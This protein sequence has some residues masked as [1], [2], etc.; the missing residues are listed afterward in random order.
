MN[1]ELKAL[2]LGI[3]MYFISQES[4]SSELHSSVTL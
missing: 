1:P 2:F 4:L 3:K